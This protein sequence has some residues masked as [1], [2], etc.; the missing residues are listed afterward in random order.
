[1]NIT[2]DEIRSKAPDGA[3][4]YSKEQRKYYKHD[5]YWKVF[6]Y[7][8]WVIAHNGEARDAEPINKVE[9]KRIK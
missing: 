4:H 6:K 9:F 3:T 7:D 1:M 8:K 2:L 5:N